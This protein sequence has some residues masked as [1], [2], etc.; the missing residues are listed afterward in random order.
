MEKHHLMSPILQALSTSV[1]M[2]L[3]SRLW[4]THQA[5]EMD[6]PGG[7]EVHA[8]GRGRVVEADNLGSLHHHYERVAA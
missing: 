7:W 2:L 5:F 1:Q 4:R 6:S 8:V 3:R